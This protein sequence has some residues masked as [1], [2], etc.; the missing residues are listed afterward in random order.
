MIIAAAIR[1]IREIRDFLD[2]A[3]QSAN[4][5]LGGDWHRPSP[6][7]S[8]GRSFANKKTDSS[9]KTSTKSRKNLRASNF[10]V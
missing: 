10:L 9:E 5:K 6:S 8:L 4:C 2:S 3:K 1:V 7:R